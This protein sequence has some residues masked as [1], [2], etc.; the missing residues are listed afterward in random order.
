[1]VATLELRQNGFVELSKS[2]LVEIDGGDVNPVLMLAFT[3]YVAATVFCPPAAGPILA[4]YG[5]YA[6]S[7][8]VDALLGL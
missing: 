3:V 4:F 7:K 8:A 5:S 6:A 2:E 1:M